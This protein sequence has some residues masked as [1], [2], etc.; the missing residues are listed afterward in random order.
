M[1]FSAG[2]RP[3]IIN[4]SN[5]LECIKLRVLTKSEHT[6]GTVE[7]YIERNACRYGTGE[8]KV[9]SQYLISYLRRS[10]KTLI[11]FRYKKTSLT[12]IVAGSKSPKKQRLPKLFKKSPLRILPQN[13]YYQLYKLS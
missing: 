10:R 8:L 2:R 12:L 1:G 13:C 3:M 6:E 11:P 5:D 4:Q 7:S 9:L